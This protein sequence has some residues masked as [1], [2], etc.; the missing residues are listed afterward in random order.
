MLFYLNNNTKL[1][2][3]KYK[4]IIL[5][6]NTT[7][8]SFTMCGSHPSVDVNQYYIYLYIYIYIYIIIKH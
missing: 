4:Y 2:I 7:S 8:H 5:V 6:H 1:Y 3:C